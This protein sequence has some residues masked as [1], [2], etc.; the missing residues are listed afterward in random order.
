MSLIW[1]FVR[2][3]A[4]QFKHW[5]I[6]GLA[7]L[8]LT[9][10][11][12]VAIP[13]FLELGLVAADP[14]VGD[15]NVARWVALIVGAAVGIIVVRTASRLL[16]FV[17]GREAEFLLRN[18]YFRHMMALQPTFYRD[19]DLGDL[20]TRGSNDIQFVRV[21]I[22]FAGLQLL[23]ILFALP[24]NLYMM[25]R[26]SWKLTIGCLLPLGLSLLIMRLGVRMMMS[27]MVAAQQELSRLSAEILESYNGVRV[28]NSYGAG[29]AMLGRFDERNEA[30]VGLHTRIAL[31]RSFLLP[32]VAVVG[33][34]GILVLL[35]W[36]GSMVARSELHFGVVAAFAAYVANIVGTLTSLGWVINVVQRGQI[37]LERVM[38]ILRADPGLPPV[39]AS[40]PDGPIGFSVEGLTFTYAGSE[41]EASLVDLTLA[42]EPGKTLGVYGATGCGKT[43]LLRIL[44]RLETP[45]PGTVFLVTPGGAR[46]DIRDVDLGELRGVLSMVQQSPYLFSRTVRENIGTAELSGPP[47]DA[48]VADAVRRASL[49]KDLAALQNGLDTIVGERGVTLSGGQRQ[50]TALARAFYKPCRVLLLDDTL[51]AVDTDTEQRLIRGIYEQSAGRTTILVSHRVSALQHADTVLVL[52]DGRVLQ[53]GEHDTLLKEGGPYADA[54]RAQ[55]DDETGVQP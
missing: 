32:V 45:P 9:N 17:P 55:Q 42:I 12:A 22:G 47:D 52:R 31:I 2:R 3:Y 51:S 18:D 40:V 49:D 29:P 33:N 50:R 11:L 1:T 35:Y 6:A 20:M 16:I 34:L 44:T 13:K 21:L 39:T 8:A 27:K 7:A 26:I 4:F 41:R 48:R 38:Q 43:T 10:V 53:H 37:S 24:L 36:G 19:N 25:S 54:W 30:Y 5:Y 23:N 15:G 28:V 46:T 14:A